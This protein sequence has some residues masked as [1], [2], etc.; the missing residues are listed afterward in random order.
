MS[1]NNSPR[2]RLGHFL[3]LVAL[4]TPL[5]GQEPPNPN[6]NPKPRVIVS[7]EALALCQGEGRAT[8]RRVFLGVEAT[9]ISPE[10]RRHFGS[11]ENRG[12]LVSKVIDGGPAARAGLAVGDVLTRCA[13]ED[14][15][16]PRD[17]RSAV[18]NRKGGESI[19]VE[20]FRDGKARTL[21]VQLDEKETCA[22]DLASVMDLSDLEELR[23]LGRLEELKALENLDIDLSGIDI[24]GLVNGAL[25]V[26]AAS[27]EEVLK[28]RDWE[29]EIEKFNEIRSEELEKR[30]QEV[31]RHL[32]QLEAKLGEEAGRYGDKARAEID[33]AREELRRELE[34]SRRE[35]EKEVRKNIE[36]AR[37][38]AERAS[39]ELEK[40]RAEADKARAKAG[41]GGEII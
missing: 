13:G 33:R 36:E 23:G 21:K 15:E 1:K 6:P 7:P 39:R 41:G 38:E 18:R 3:I 35:I 2:T 37:R 24:E 40:A 32:E 27:V 26:A 14:V 12:V 29:K 25:G 4:S 34:K 11:P 9:P 16:K 30:M 19:E 28:N 5:F 17:L 20:L 10:L 22:F 8:A 31:A